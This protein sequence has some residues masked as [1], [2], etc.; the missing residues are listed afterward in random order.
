METFAGY[1][2]TVYGVGAAV[3]FLGYCVA[4]GMGKAD[5]M[6]FTSPAEV[7]FYALAIAA[8]WPMIAVAATAARIGA[9]LRKD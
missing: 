4:A 3:V 1:A 8:W 5:R 6:R 2:A 7:S 9:M